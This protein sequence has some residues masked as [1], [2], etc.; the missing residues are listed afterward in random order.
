MS[1]HSPQHRS[2]GALNASGLPDD[3]L[4]KLGVQDG[5]DLPVERVE[6]PCRDAGRAAQLEHA[7]RDIRRRHQ[8]GGFPEDVEGQQRCFR[9]SEDLV[10][11]RPPWQLDGRE[12]KGRVDQANG[13]IDMTYGL[14]AA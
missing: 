13:C 8:P 5:V 11:V 10:L 1:D 7:L 14:L 6:L 2:I 9:G 3:A 12:V 4:S